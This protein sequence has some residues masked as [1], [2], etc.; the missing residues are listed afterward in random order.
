MIRVV[1]NA[2]DEVFD[3]R[4]CENLAEVLQRSD[5]SGEAEAHLYT[6]IRIDGL[7]LPEDSFSRL[8]EISIAGVERIEVE[9]RPSIE[10]AISSLRHSAEYIVPVRRAVDRVVGLFRRGRSDEANDL[11]ADLSDSLGILVAAVTGTA[12]VIPE[13]AE[14]LLTPIQELVEWLDAVING[15]GNG[16]WVYVADLLEYEIDPRLEDWGRAMTQVLGELA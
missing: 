4:D 14:R 3:C 6:H 13:T 11:L 2:V 5:R 9:S 10:I 15:Q 7:D 8:D 12:N 16:D 1:H